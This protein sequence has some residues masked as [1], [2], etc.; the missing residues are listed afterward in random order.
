[1]EFLD[2]NYLLDYKGQTFTDKLKES[3]ISHVLEVKED[4]LGYTPRFT[5]IGMVVSHPTEKMPE[6]HGVGASVLL[7]EDDNLVEDTVLNNFMA[8]FSGW[9]SPPGITQTR[10]VKDRSG[11]DNNVIV[12]GSGTPKIFNRIAAGSGRGTA[13][14]VGSGTTIPLRTDVDIETPFLDNPQANA[15]NTNDGGWNSALGRVSVTKSIATTTSGG[16]V[17][18][19]GLFHFMN[20]NLDVRVIT[21]ITHDKITPG[22]PF[23]I[24]E[25]LNTTCTFTY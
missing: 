18:E 11:V 5:D 10:I 20:N 22:V 17:G 1:M 14:Q 9:F 7:K 8:W 15:S 23:L 21:M 25:T 16:T 6:I 2:N 13:V 3:M 19:I 12:V 4:R 24:G